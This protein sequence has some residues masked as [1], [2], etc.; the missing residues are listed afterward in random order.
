MSDFYEV[1]ISG[2]KENE[3]RFTFSGFEQLEF[4][5]VST[6]KAF[7]RVWKLLPTSLG[8][9]LVGYEDALEEANEHF[10][11]ESQNDA[12]DLDRAYVSQALRG[13]G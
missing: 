11:N 5:E 12:D 4:V 8:P 9:D 2:S 7:P 10:S 6:C 13:V 3:I 1:S